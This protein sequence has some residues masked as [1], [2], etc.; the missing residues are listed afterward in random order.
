MCREDYG[1]CDC[2]VKVLERGVFECFFFSVF[3]TLLHFVV[4][5]KPRLI[6][7]CYCFEYRPRISEFIV[8]N[9]F[10]KEQ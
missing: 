10:P 8:N 3:A 1:E 7:S 6:V 4:S 5:T 2:F 9:R